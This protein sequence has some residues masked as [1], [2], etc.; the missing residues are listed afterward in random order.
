MP[1]E[2]WRR[3][4]VSDAVLEVT[5]RGS[6]EPLVLIQTALIADE[7]LPLADDPGLR[8]HFRVIAHHRRGYGRSSPVAGAGSI[9]RDADD[10]RELLAGLGVGRAHVVGLSYSGAVA[11]QL[12]RSAPD[13]VHSLCLIEPPP[14][15]TPSAGEFVAANAEL[16]DLY[17]RNGVPA[18]LDRFGDFIGAD[19]RR[20]LERRLPG[21]GARAERDA[22]T[23]FATDLPALLS[24]RFGPDDAR[25]IGQ[26]VLHVGGTE[27][28]P[29]FAEVRELVL[30]WLP[31]AEDVVLDGA[32]HS[33][34]LTHTSELG[35]A[36]ASFLRRHPM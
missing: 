14:L 27:S 16:T 21:A 31:H 2:A 35:E 6:G 23:F 17:R 1:T 25:R 11:L 3:V 26:P 34:A 10:C 32:D 30:A 12:A 22:G 29:W 20:V 28:G 9:E 24:W 5:D 19:W 33:L 4:S 7:L 13:L 36:L 15:H 18:A 8:D